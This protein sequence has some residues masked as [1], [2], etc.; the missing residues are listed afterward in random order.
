VTAAV[1]AVPSAEQLET[2]LAAA[3]AAEKWDLVD[4]LSAD[5]EALEDGADPA[6]LARLDE[7]AALIES[8]ATE[9][10]AC[11]AV[12][13]LPAA[14]RLQR[15]EATRRLR[16]EY[17]G[18]SFDDLARQ[19]YRDHVHAAYVAAEEA[20]RGHL[21]NRVGRASGVDPLSL[22]TGPLVRATK[23][24][25]DELLEWWEACGRVTF[26][27]WREQLLTGTCAADTRFRGSG[28]QLERRGHSSGPIAPSHPF[29]PERTT[30]MTSALNAGPNVVTINVDSYDGRGAH[31][32]TSRRSGPARSR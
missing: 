3:I 10:D 22:F 21:V 31:R 24:A 6:D 1:A 26:D 25:S 19:S 7:V 23:Y 32:T 30:P 13:G 15:Q 17:T 11:A 14:E 28:R 18:R 27:E 16:Q 9:F 20:C 8:G 2:A 29:V 4:A 5:V 12:Y